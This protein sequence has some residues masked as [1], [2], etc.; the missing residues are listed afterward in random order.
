[1]RG[2]GSGHAAPAFIADVLLGVYII[3]YFP[4]GSFCWGVAYSRVHSSEG[5]DSGSDSR[6]EVRSG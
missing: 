5:A 1:M 6:D 2:G 3:C 4:V